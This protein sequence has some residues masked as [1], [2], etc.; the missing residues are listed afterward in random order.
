[1]CFY[2]W[3]EVS[4]P[5]LRVAEMIL[6]ELQQNLGCESCN[7]SEARVTTMASTTQSHSGYSR[8]NSSNK[9]YLGVAT[10][11]FGRLVCNILSYIP[12]LGHKVDSLLKM[13]KNKY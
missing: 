4:T 8:I 3:D 10:S 1:M 2:S 12:L 6:S 11:M 13:H 5:F 9:S 7:Y